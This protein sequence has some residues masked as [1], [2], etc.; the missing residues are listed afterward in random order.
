MGE[1]NNTLLY[2]LKEDLQDAFED[3]TEYLDVSV[4]TSYD[5]FSNISYPCVIIY[6]LDNTYNDRYYDKREHVKNLSYQFTIM[7]EG[8]FDDDAVKRVMLIRQFIEN[9]LNNEKYTCLRQISV[10][11]VER[12]PNDTN[13][14]IGYMRYDCCIDIDTNTIYRRK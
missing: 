2:Q 11:G 9:Y 13:I 7:S 8:V 14:K 12:H 6:E 5:D 3:S 10:T 4:K 1:L